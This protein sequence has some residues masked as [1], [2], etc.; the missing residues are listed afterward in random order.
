MRLL[1]YTFVIRKGQAVADSMAYQAAFGLLPTAGKLNQPGCRSIIKR[2]L[3]GQ[4]NSLCEMILVRG[5]CSSSSSSR[6]TSISTSCFLLGTIGAI[7]MTMHTDSMKAKRTIRKSREIFFS[8]FTL[9]SINN[10]LLSSD[11]N[12]CF[13]IESC[14]FK[15]KR[16]DYPIEVKLSFPEL[17]DFFCK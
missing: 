9:Y 4:G 3:P 1:K 6:M 8:V 16:V 11:N 15:D 10:L 17:G 2:L 7:P 14:P 5:E 12:K 13:E